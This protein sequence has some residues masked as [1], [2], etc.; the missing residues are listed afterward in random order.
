MLKCFTKILKKTTTIQFLVVRYFTY[1]CAYFD[2]THC[3]RVRLSIT[4]DI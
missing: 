4:V 2:V 3:K 1:Y